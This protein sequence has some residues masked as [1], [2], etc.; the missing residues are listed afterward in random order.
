MTENT[1]R[2]SPTGKSSILPFIY[3][4]LIAAA[5]V[6]L[7]ILLMGLV[8]K[9]PTDANPADANPIEI[10]AGDP[11]ADVKAP[12]TSTANVPAEQVAP[13]SPLPQKKAM[14]LANRLGADATSLVG[15]VSQ[16]AERLDTKERELAGARSLY[17]IA[18][19]QLGQ[20]ESDL[21]TATLKARE[22][23]ALQARI[24]EANELLALANRRSS[25]LMAKLAASPDPATLRAAQAM[26]AKFE[27]ELSDTKDRLVRDQIE[28]EKLR[29]ELSAANTE[30]AASETALEATS[31]FI[32]SID[33]LPKSA[34]QLFLELSRLETVDRSELKKNYRLIAENLGARVVDTVPFATGSSE[35]SSSKAMSIRDAMTK[36]RDDSFFL[37]IGYAS[38]TGNFEINK[39]LSSARATAVATLAEA[40]AQPGQMVRAV[41][42]GQTD[43]FSSTDV[44][45][46]QI[47]E[48]WEIPK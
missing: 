41:F 1:P 6:G 46:D 26:R 27:R 9:K 8:R 19:R 30:L 20:L 2:P 33:L 11:V 22:V 29:A 23:E 5:A 40:T 24:V 43:R 36:G 34:K 37:V 47:C 10:D 17:A 16:L 32:S 44:L 13:A 15:M 18:A 25:A 35:V 28:K 42:L 4:A 7:V 14:D 38:K 3:G 45:D 39:T 12:T 21:A 48:L 31:L